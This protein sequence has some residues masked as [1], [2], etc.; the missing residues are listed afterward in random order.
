MLTL[1]DFGASGNC[2]KVRLLLSLLRVPYNR[3][4]VDILKDESRTEKFLTDV[5]LTGQVPIIIIPAGYEHMKRIPEISGITNS[6][7][8][9]IEVQVGNGIQSTTLAESN[10]ILIYLATNTPLLP[11][12]PLE[13]AQVLQWL[14]WEQYSHQP[15]IATLRWWILFLNRSEDPKYL[16]Q[17]VEK[18]R[19]GYEALN[20]M[21]RHLE[22]RQFF[23][24]DRFT[25]ADI[26]LYAHTHCA[27]EGG[28]SID[29]FPKVKAW[30]RRI[31]EKPGYIPIND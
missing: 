7:D 15:N 16:D 13:Y 1:H 29:S 22:T 31:E 27:E 4:D 12:N 3:V 18:Q 2:Y 28:F 20:I 11:S 5:S 6:G 26:A 30:L 9:A 14:F 21:E 10:A 8:S 23:V 25:I 17:I 24:G 19:Y